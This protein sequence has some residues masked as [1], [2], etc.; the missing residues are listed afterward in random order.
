MSKDKLTKRRRMAIVRLYSGS[1]QAL[2]P[3]SKDKLTKR[4][5][6]A[7]VRSSDDDTDLSLFS[8]SPVC[9]GC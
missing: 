7:I 3:V 6:M 8:R 5:R 9:Y 2:V 4:R 1:I